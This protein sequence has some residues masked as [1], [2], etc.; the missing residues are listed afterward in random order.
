MTRYRN[1]RPA[2]DQYSAAATLYFALTGKN[3][4]DLPSDLGEQIAYIV[5][6]APVPIVDRRTDLP[7]GLAAVIHKA[8]SREPGERYGDVMGF[9][10]ELKRFA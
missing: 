7:A 5:T 1:V 6:A 3:V 10:K 9:R 8:L 2:A 4:H